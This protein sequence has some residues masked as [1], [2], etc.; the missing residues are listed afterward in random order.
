MPKW[1]NLEDPSIYD[2]GI[3]PYTQLDSEE[4]LT[5]YTDFEKHISQSLSKFSLDIHDNNPIWM[6]IGAKLGF[7]RLYYLGS[8]VLAQMTNLHDIDDYMGA[9]Y[10]LPIT[11]STKYLKDMLIEIS[12]KYGPI[13]NVT[14]EFCQ[15]LYLDYD[16]QYD[17]IEYYIFTETLHK[18]THLNDKHRDGL[19]KRFSRLRNRY[20]EAGSE[21]GNVMLLPRFSIVD[22]PGDI[23]KGL[24][25]FQQWEDSKISDGWKSND[26]HWSSCYEYIIAHPKEVQKFFSGE[27]KGF[28]IQD[29][30]T[31]DYIAIAIGTPFSDNSW[32]NIIR[33]SNYKD[34][35][36]ISDLAL[37][38]LSSH[39]DKLKYPVLVDGQT[40][41]AVGNLKT[42]KECY[43][44]FTRRITRIVP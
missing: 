38:I 41:Q 43:C 27:V 26:F 9:L 6:Y 18:M 19:K 33:L 25:L 12:Q 35:P 31:Y 21:P 29:K 8:C 7:L 32:S 13:C 3:L 5:I 34:Y 39:Y 15:G 24:K 20:I 17:V 40:A 42:V 11:D 22:Y 2:R 1:K 10:I 44:D 36:C 23:E 16:E 14:E 4:F 28:Y 30:N 37:Y